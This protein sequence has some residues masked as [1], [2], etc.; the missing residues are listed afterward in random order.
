MGAVLL[1]TPDPIWGLSPPSGTPQRPGVSQDDGVLEARRTLRGTLSADGSLRRQVLVPADTLLQL[2]VETGGVDL[3]VRVEGPAGERLVERACRQRGPTSISLVTAVSGLHAVTFE[4]Q[5]PPVDD[6]EITVEVAPLRPVRPGDEHLVAAERSLAEATRQAEA[7]NPGARDAALERYEASLHH[8]RA[9]GVRTGEIDTLNAL[10]QLRLASGAPREALGSFSQALQLSRDLGDAPREAETASHLAAAYRHLGDNDRALRHVHAALDLC[11]ERGCGWQRAQALFT[12]GRIRYGQ[13]EMRH[14]LRSFTAALTLWEQQRDRRG[15]AEAL[16]YSGFVHSVL[17]N[18][19]QAMACQE[20][21]LALWSEVNDRRGRARA[22]RALGYVYSAR[23][24]RQKALDMYHEAREILGPTGDRAALAAVLNGLGQV[25][26][27][28]DQKP[29]ALRYYREALALNRGARF[30]R[31]EAGTLVEIGRCHDALGDT[32]EALRQYELALA[33]YRELGDTRMEAAVLGDIGNIHL[34]SGDPRTALTYHLTA[35]P[36]KHAAEDR[37]E[38]ALT[39]NDIGRVYHLLGDSPAASEHFR[40]ALELAKQVD[41]RLGEALTLLNTAHLERDEGQL[42]TAAAHLATSLEIIESRRARV[43]SHELKAS[44]LASMQGHYELYIDVLMQLHTREG[45]P[46]LQARALQVSERARARALMDSLG[47]GAA[48]I[49]EGVDPELLRRERA[50]RQRLNAAAERQMSPASRD[51]GDRGELSRELETLSTELDEVLGQI[52]SHSPRY[53]ALTQ[54]EPLSLEQIRGSVLDEDTL[55]LEYALGGERSYLWAVGREKTTSHVLPGRGRIESVARRV[56]KLLTAREPVPGETAKQRRMREERADAEYCSRAAE[57]STMLLGPVARRLG[58]KRL[59]VVS[60]GALLYVPFAA[61]PAPDATAG[62]DGAEPLGVRHEIVRLPSASTL[63]VLRKETADR[64]PP[65]KTVAVLADPVFTAD[66]PRLGPGEPGRQGPERGTGDTPPPP[67]NLDRT[68]RDVGLLRDG[69][70]VPRLLATRREARA[71][72]DVAPPGS[73]MMALGFE[74]SR[75]LATSPALG[76]YRVVHFATHGILN[77]EHPELSGMILS[78]VDEHGRPSDG[79]LR[80][81]D[82]YNLDLPVELVVL[83]ACRTGLGREI[84]GEGLVGIV[85]G[86]MYAGAPRVVA[87]SWKV[88]DEATAALM[89]SF[90][91]GLLRRG[92]SVGAALRAAQLEMRQQGRWRAP[93]YWAAFE[94]Q[95]EWR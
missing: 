91:D 31:G 82:I 7:W 84:R 83:S 12:L 23:G 36:L 47:E 24:E 43:T 1:S 81:H 21:A 73:A 62:P 17:G 11:R 34:Q 77:D 28:L 3:E 46:D 76:E 89:T 67:S 18:G 90:Y 59:V 75:T 65:R 69:F 44:Y 50:L 51:D 13:G 60:E 54:P 16:L 66:D 80:L 19:D 39:H 93:F 56:Y 10:G 71:I 88:D 49:R 68:M 41:D 25:Y 9:A 2:T 20:R 38:E 22:L 42:D 37:R 55:L 95:G 78:L 58:K 85:R 87:S 64:K 4:A 27:D 48:N 30:L 35:L 52:R 15:Q 70:G 29:A 79:F 57:L 92:L 5:G 72:V 94:L 32:Q 74:A 6:A 53:A 86:F 40:R 63:A 61:L 33:A 26:Y 8:W 45:D 14:A